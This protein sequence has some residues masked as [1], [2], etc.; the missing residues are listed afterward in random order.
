M[1]FGIRREPFQRCV[2]VEV[3]KHGV[4]LGAL[5]QESVDIVAMKRDGGAA[6]G[7]DFAD[8]E[9]RRCADG[10]TAGRTPG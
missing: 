8:A 10:G 9:A 7:T 1:E 4:A 5:S 3:G 2:D 6:A